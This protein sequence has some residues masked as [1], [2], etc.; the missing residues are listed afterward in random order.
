MDPELPITL[1]TSFCGSVSGRNK[2]TTG[3][4]GE[5]VVLEKAACAADMAAPPSM[6]RLEDN[7]SAREEANRVTAEVWKEGCGR[8]LGNSDALYGDCEEP[9][10]RL[11]LRRLGRIDWDGVFYSFLFSLFQIKT[12]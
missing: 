5:A 3:P 8:P 1:A 12:S 4:L 2:D 7:I 10:N 11:L 9:P 6:R